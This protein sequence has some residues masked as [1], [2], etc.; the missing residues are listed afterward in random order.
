MLGW[1]CSIVGH[2]EARHPKEMKVWVY[3]IEVWIPIPD[4]RWVLICPRCH[5]TL[6]DEREEPIRV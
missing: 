3:G 6:V 5:A 1:I 2:A 4:N